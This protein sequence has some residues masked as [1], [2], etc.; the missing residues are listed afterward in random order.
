[1]PRAT[2]F[3]VDVDVDVRIARPK[4]RFDL[5]PWREVGVV[6]DALTHGAASHGD[7]GW[8]GV[9]RDDHFAAA[10]RHLTAWRCGTALDEDSGLPHLAH[11]ACRVL[12]LLAVTRGDE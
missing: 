6:V 2:T 1:M 3:D 12:F 4:R 9:S 11:A 5:L 7:Y 8:R 10:L